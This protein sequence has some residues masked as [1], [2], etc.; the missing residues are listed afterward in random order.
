MT[1]IIREQHQTISLAPRNVL[2]VVAS[3]TGTGSIVRL[4][5][6]VGDPKQGVTSL[7]A[8]QTVTFGPFPQTT[9]YD[10]VC[11]AGSL[12]FETAVADFPAS[13]DINAIS[14]VTQAQYDALTPDAATLYLIVG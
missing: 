3:A 9:W 11:S 7:A 10:I 6:F 5:E 12:V 4:G 1:V 2:S 14:K 13:T 8:G